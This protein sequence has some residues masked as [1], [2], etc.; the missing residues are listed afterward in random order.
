MGFAP[1]RP[2]VGIDGHICNDKECAKWP[3]VAGKKKGQ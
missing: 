3:V 1:G 2:E